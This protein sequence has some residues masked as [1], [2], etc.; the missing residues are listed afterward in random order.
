M[1]GT[2]SPSLRMFDGLR[3][4]VHDAGGVHRCHGLGHQFKEPEPLLEGQSAPRRRKRASRDPLH[5]D[6]WLPRPRLVGVRRVD[7]DLQHAADRTVS[8]RGH[9]AR[10]AD[11]GGTRSLAVELAQ[12]LDRDPSV[13]QRVK[14]L[15]HGSHPARARLGDHPVAR[16]E[17]GRDPAAG[18]PCALCE[19]GISQGSGV[20]R[21]S[22][23]HAQ[24]GC[25]PPRTGGS[26]RAGARRPSGARRRERQSLVIA[27]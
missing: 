21:V 25:G 1:T 19:A 12:E 4:S 18:G 5:H 24:I 13:K 17:V 8:Q 3:F 10:L 14:R 22:G 2:P 7:D 11:D 9:C 20:V 16:P 15:S 27:A 6:E 23:R 26:G